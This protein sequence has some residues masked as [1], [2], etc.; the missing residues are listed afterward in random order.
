M[1][2]SLGEAVNF[3]IYIYIYIHILVNYKAMC[4][5]RPILGSSVVWVHV[6]RVRLLTVETSLH[7]CRTSNDVT[8]CGKVSKSK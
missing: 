6:A 8:G 1:K 2:L 5:H 4:L 3:N 7:L